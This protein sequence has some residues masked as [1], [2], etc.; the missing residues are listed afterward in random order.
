MSVE[1]LQDKENSGALFSSCKK[2]KMLSTDVAKQTKVTVILGAHWSDESKGKVVD[3]LS[4]DADIVCRC[5]GGSNAGHTVV[6]DDVKY[7]TLAL[8]LL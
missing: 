7:S 8:N 3:M 1:N 2:L 4:A 6:V 5:Q